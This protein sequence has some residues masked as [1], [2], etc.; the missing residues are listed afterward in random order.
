MFVSAYQPVNMRFFLKNFRNFK[1]KCNNCRSNVVCV[2]NVTQKHFFEDFLRDG[3]AKGGLG[4]PW[5]PREPNS[6]LGAKF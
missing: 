2:P 1:S 6:D 4:G 5:L 3:G